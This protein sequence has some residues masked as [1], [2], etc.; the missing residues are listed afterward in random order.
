MWY[1]RYLD[2]LAD[3]ESSGHLPDKWNQ[4]DAPVTR[5]GFVYRWKREAPVQGGTISTYP[6]TLAHMVKLTGPLPLSR[7]DDAIVDRAF[8]LQEQF[9]DE[10]LRRGLVDDDGA[11]VKSAHGHGHGHSSKD[12]ALVEM[13][14]NNHDDMAAYRNAGDVPKDDGDIVEYLVNRAGGD[15]GWASTATTVAAMARA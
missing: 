14:M 15:A 7:Q 12:R 4:H 9:E 2:F 6:F 11:R 5:E 3:A 13:N 1:S 8:D 10:L